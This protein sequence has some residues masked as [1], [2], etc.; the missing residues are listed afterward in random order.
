MED[1]ELLYYSVQ[2]SNGETREKTDRA[3][4]LVIFDVWSHKFPEDTVELVEIWGKTVMSNKPSAAEKT[5]P[6]IEA[7]FKI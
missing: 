2:R 7:S 3:E 5:I 4:A 6:E 1:A